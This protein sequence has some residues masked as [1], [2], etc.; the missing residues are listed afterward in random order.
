MKNKK[1]FADYA[2]AYNKKLD[3]KTPLPEGFRV[4]NPFKKNETGLRIMK[5]FYQKFYNDQQPRK[6]LLGINPGR[7]GAGVTGVPFTDTKRLRENCGIE[8]EGKE[9]H[10]PSASFIYRMI[11]AYGGVE[12]FYKDIYIHS[13]FPLAIV[14]KNNK[15]VFVNCNYYDDKRLMASLRPYMLGHLKAQ[16]KWGLKTDVVY[17]L[18]KKN[19]KFIEQLNAET[20]LFKRMEILEHPRYIQQYKSKQADEYA[21]KFVR[22]L[23]A[24]I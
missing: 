3:L 5:L 24:A 12:D 1:T 7:F 2:I 18:G 15:G 20:K 9:T 8:Y 4:M 19:A 13:I 16:I 23:K 17:V 6:L 21:E 22:V 11:A 10:E 14:Q